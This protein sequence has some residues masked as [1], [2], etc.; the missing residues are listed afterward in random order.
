MASTAQTHHKLRLIATSSSPFFYTQYRF[1]PG[2]SSPPPSL[3]RRC[4]SLGRR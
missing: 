3:S 4:R 1:S 2:A